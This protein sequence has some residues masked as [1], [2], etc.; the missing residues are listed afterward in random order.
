MKRK[1]Y[2]FKKYKIRVILSLRLNIPTSQLYKL[3]GE[4][5]YVIRVVCPNS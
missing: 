4:K 1:M 5:L 3:V 2:L